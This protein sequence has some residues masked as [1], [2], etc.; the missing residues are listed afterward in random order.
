MVVL[1]VAVSNM[2]R[3]VD[4]FFVEQACQDVDRVPSDAVK[5]PGHPFDCSDDL[6]NISYHLAFYD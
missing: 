4:G 5:V 2:S 1:P 3:Y 6:L